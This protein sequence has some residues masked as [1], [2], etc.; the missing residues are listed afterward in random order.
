MN[1]HCDGSGFGEALGRVEVE[2]VSI[3]STLGVLEIAVNAKPGTGSRLDSS[4]YCSQKKETQQSLV[5]EKL[6]WGF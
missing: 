4:A 5:H 1:P 2:L 3:C 6:L